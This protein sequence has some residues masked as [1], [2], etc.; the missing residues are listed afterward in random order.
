MHT[1]TGLL[2]KR[3]RLREGLSVRHLAEMAT[4]S[5]SVINAL[6]KG[7]G[8]F[9]KVLIEHI[10]LK[11]GVTIKDLIPDSITYKEDIQFDMAIDL[12]YK[13]TRDEKKAITPVI[14]SLAKAYN[15]N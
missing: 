9:E 7:E 6:E 12:L 15:F 8:I 14:Q 2:I 4:T 11:L 5:T 13:L 1:I 3:Y 10:A